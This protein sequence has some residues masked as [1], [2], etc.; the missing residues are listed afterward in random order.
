M[1]S[2]VPERRP[3]PRP[4]PPKGVPLAIKITGCVG[5]LVAF[6][7]GAFGLVLHGSLEDTIRAQIQNEAVNAARTAAQADVDTWAWSFSTIDQGLTGEQI[8]ARVDMQSP[9]EFMV[10]DQDPVRRAQIEWNQARFKRFLGENTRVLAVE[11]FR[12]QNGRRG[13]T[14][15]TAYPT[16]DGASDA[17]FT[18]IADRPPVV[19]GRGMAQ[20][21]L[22]SVGPNT[23]LVI[24]GSYPIL[25]PAGEM[26]GEVVV[27]IHAAAIQEAAKEFSFRVTYAGGVFLVVAC[28]LAL[29]MAQRITSPV[30][31]LQ[32]DAHA[33]V[34]GD[35]HH[36]TRPHSRDEIGDLARTFEHMTRWL[37]E[38]R[39]AEHE[40]DTFRHELEAAA[41]VTASLFPKT[42]PELPG[43]SLGGLHD[44]E[45]SPGGGTYDV[46]Q[47][48]GGK[49]G[50]LLAEA[51]SGG[52]PGALL[53][54]MARSTLRFAAERNSD[55]TAVLREANER[56]APDLGD[57]LKVAVLLAVLDP[58]TGRVQV[59]N[60]GHPSLMHYHAAVDGLEPVCS[61]GIA[62]GADEGAVFDA[63]LKVAE[64]TVEPGDRLVMFA[65]AIAWLPG[66]DGEVLGEKRL[67]GLIKQAGGLPADEL[68]ERVASTLRAYH[69]EP[70]LGADVTLVA[71]G[72]DGDPGAAQGAAQGALQG[73]DASKA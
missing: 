29:L 33:V 38:A 54:A 9:E 28:L 42:L 47:M 43:W 63:T 27:H 37:A 66:P 36:H 69:G 21:G 48:P 26:D 13:L 35:L 3:V 10:Y 65:K 52:A 40:A 24:R 1:S 11:I 55:P 20:E 18:T 19:M 32:D 46:L 71:L 59:A 57:G 39:E 70:T 41:D 68:V 30:R 4:A 34:E 56:L 16:V 14:I 2:Q 6:F 62:L 73:A 45:S 64:L 12:W 5:L 51:S 61:E 8:Q 49:L 60:A 7:M 22:L 58:A 44:R 15:G 31:L 67:G 50:L 53:A 23:W 72:R 25:D 17:E